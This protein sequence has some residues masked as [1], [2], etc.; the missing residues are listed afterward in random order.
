[1][2]RGNARSFIRTLVILIMI[3]AC[4][5][6]VGGK[7][8]GTLPNTGSSNVYGLSM[9]NIDQQTAK[10]VTNLLFSNLKVPSITMSIQASL[11]IGE[12]Q[13]HVF[14]IPHSLPQWDYSYNPAM[15]FVHEINMG[16]FGKIVAME[17]GMPLKVEAPWTANL[18]R[19]MI[20]LSKLQGHE[21]NPELNLDILFLNFLMACI[22]KSKMCL[23]FGNKVLCP[24]NALGKFAIELKRKFL[25]SRNVA[26]ALT[27]LGTAAT[28]YYGITDVLKLVNMDAHT[29]KPV[30]PCICLSTRI[31]HGDIQTVNEIIDIF[32]KKLMQANQ[33][34][35][36]GYPRTTQGSLTGETLEREAPKPPPP[37]NQEVN[38]AMRF[39]LSH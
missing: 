6:T 12:Y 3:F 11:P 15:D 32:L 33:G 27:E 5:G 34:N 23:S 36:K 8:S 38:R 2:A 21:F 30:I 20:T 25:E 28:G 1:M 29:L 19:K 35:P 9:L 16:F 13:R 10:Y 18:K 14:G 24:P 39:L 7:S 17:N 26:G 37:S 4:T 31:Y 22:E